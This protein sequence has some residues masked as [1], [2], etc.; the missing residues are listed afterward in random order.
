MLSRREQL[1]R[2]RPLSS[3]TGIDI[4]ADICRGSIDPRGARVF[5]SRNKITPALPMRARFFREIESKALSIYAI[6]MKF[7]LPNFHFHY[8]NCSL[9][10]LEIRETPST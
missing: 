3:A 5:G 7:P 8:V 1:K 2:D 10:L 6:V 4:G 9:S